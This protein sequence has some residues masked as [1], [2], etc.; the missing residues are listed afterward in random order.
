LD[1][2]AP[3]DLEAGGGRVGALL[4]SP[5]I[6]AG[7]TIDAPYDQFSLLASIEELFG[8]DPIGYAKDTKL[9]PFGPKVYG[10][11]SPMADAG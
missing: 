5:Y 2:G 6:T 3:T 11:W 4:L 10:A 8:L 1:A 7:G 9:K